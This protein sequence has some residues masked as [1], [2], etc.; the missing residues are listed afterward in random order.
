MGVISV[1]VK[2]NRETVADCT[3]YVKVSGDV[4]TRIISAEKDGNEVSV[5]REKVWRVPNSIEGSVAGRED[6]IDGLQGLGVAKNNVR[7]GFETYEGDMGKDV[8]FRITF[9]WRSCGDNLG[10]LEKE[11]FKGVGANGVPTKVIT[12]D[13]LTGIS[14]SCVGKRKDAKEAIYG[15]G[16]G[17]VTSG[18]AKSIFEA[19]DKNADSLMAVK[20]VGRR[21]SI[22][23]D[24]TRLMTDDNGNVG[25]PV[26]RKIGVLGLKGWQAIAFLDKISGVVF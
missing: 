15:K 12:L 16:S 6:G 14:I 23:C 21:M 11:N 18:G 7:V 2:G 13:F 4:V 9:G 3:V 22:N 5:F 19:K 24:V 1:K 10:G 25:L 26:C 8:L 17:Y 20:D